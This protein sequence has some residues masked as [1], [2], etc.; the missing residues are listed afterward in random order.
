LRLA[1]DHADR[2]SKSNPNADPGWFS[3][4]DTN[5]DSYADSDAH[6]VRLSGE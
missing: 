3:D 6:A 4:A 2:W 1:G 5:S